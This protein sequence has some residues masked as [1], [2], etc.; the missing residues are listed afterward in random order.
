M[1]PGN[2]FLAS[3]CLS[4]AL[5]AAVPASP[6]R[7][8]GV[9]PKGNDEP[10]ASCSELHLSF[11][12]HR[13]VLQSEERTITR[14]EAG[15]LRIQAESNGG[16]QVVGW[17]KDTYG[18]TLCKGADSDG[19]AEAV[20]SKI[21]ITFQNGELGVSG[22]PSHDRWT[23]HLL[24]KAPK[25]ASLDLQVNNGP[26]SLFGVAGNVRVRAKNGPLRVKS[27]TG[28]LDLNAQ[29]GPVDLE[30]NSG[31]LR[32]EAQNGPVT[33]ALD[34]TAWHGAGVE[35]HANNGPLTLRI[36]PGYQSGVLLESN[37]HS[38]FQCN[39]AVCSEGRKTWGDDQK[40][41]EFGSGPMLVHLT[42]ANGPVSIH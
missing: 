14:E 23:A 16:M 42:T 19:D 36:P 30:G 33:L 37:G 18:V 7:E 17:D 24:V 1:N 3:I 13:A 25:A 38:P 20:L 31:Q 6:A 2:L 41:I 21:H 28:H 11:D 29:N 27:C 32:V 39:A 35:A 12:H 9:I 10:V 8:P 5:V 4:A 22:P 15:T 26:L 40:S 34:G